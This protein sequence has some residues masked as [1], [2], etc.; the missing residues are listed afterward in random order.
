MLYGADNFGNV[1][2]TEQTMQKIFFFVFQI[3]MKANGVSTS[4]VKDEVEAI[5][6]DHEEGLCIE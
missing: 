3:G 2:K 4:D 6:V 1:I 5:D